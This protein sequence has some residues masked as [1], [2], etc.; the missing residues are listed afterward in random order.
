MTKSIDLVAYNA[1]KHFAG[2][3]YPFAIKITTPFPD[4]VPLKSCGISETMVRLIGDYEP[5][6]ETNGL[7]P[8]QGDFFKVYSENIDRNFIM[9]TATGCYKAKTR[10]QRKQ[11]LFKSKKTYY[12]IGEMI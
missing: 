3:I 5:K 7:F 8:N 12:V 4:R 10:N 9:P 11:K 2:A 6:A 1:F